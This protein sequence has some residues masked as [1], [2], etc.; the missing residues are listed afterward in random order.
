MMGVGNTIMQIGTG[1][2]TA[3]RRPDETRATSEIYD[4]MLRLARVAEDVGLDS[5]WVSEHHFSDDGYLPG[6]MP[7]LGA[8]AGIT[9]SIDLGTYI[10]IA[11]LYDPVRLAENAATVDLISDGRLTL[12]LGLGYREP[13]FE[14]FGVPTKER[15]DRLEDTIDVLKGSWTPGPISHDSP[16]HDVSP[17]TTVLPKPVQDPHPSIILGAMARPAVRRA[18]IKGQGWAAI[19]NMSLEALRKRKEHIDA[20]REEHGLSDDYTIYVAKYGFIGETA[21][22][23]WEAI[24][25]GYLHMQR[26]YAE[27]QTGEKIDRLRDEQI[28]DVKDDVL[29]G[30]PAE[31]VEELERY[32]EVIGDDAHLMFRTY[33][34]GIG[35]DTMA[36]CIETLGDEV[37]PELR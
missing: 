9:D 35:T 3:Q 24:K 26:K 22:A 32:R 4:E 18:A 28:A 36:S 7:T 12:G 23:A 29:L 33:Y 11:P 21:E 10:A 13:E 31:I 15:A 20:V 14:N 5:I 25:D 37:A 2:L 16:F 6:T 1:L 19:G 8:I 27:W 30:P 17:E 34:P